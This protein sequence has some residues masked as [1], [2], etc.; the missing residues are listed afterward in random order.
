MVAKIINY[1]VK[2]AAVLQPCGTLPGSGRGGMAYCFHLHLHYPRHG[3]CS[4]VSSN[5]APSTSWSRFDF[6]GQ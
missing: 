6:S 1:E 3:L 4:E 2:A 5:A